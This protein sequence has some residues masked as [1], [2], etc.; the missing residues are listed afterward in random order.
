MAHDTDTRPGNVDAEVDSPPPVQ[1]E[2]SGAAFS[3][4]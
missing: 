1:R 4:W 3:G 2:R